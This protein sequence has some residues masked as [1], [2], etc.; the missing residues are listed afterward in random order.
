MSLELN[1]IEEPFVFELKNEEGVIC[2]IDASPAIGGKGKG[3]RPMELL[4]GSLAGC[5][6][7]D[8]LLIL[9][10]QRIEPTHFNVKIETKRSS[11]VPAIFEEI[12]L[13]F[14]VNDLVNQ[15]KLEKAIGLTLEKY[16]SVSA[17]LKENISVIYEVKYV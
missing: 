11:G 6:S 10:K 16:C 1:R 15:E 3:L 8:I 7:I 13:I 2:G 14:E 4:A 9:K 17:S 12:K 5:A